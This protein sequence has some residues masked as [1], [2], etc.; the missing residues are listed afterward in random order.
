[1]ELTVA[2]TAGPPG[3][4]PLGAGVARRGA[5]AR[6]AALGERLAAMG[7][8]VGAAVGQAAA[9]GWEVGRWA[10]R[11]DSRTAPRVAAMAAA[12][13]G[14]GESLAAA[15]RVVVRKAARWVVRVGSADSAAGW[16]AASAAGSG[17]PPA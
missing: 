14:G 4:V 2:G 10:E 16:V 5:A 15:A 3:A 11:R 7:W 9:A 8:L 13:W 1:M 6:T 17:S 12:G